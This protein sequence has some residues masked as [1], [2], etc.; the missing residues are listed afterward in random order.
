[1]KKHDDKWYKNFPYLTNKDISDVGRFN[2]P[3]LPILKDKVFRTKPGE[4]K[5]EDISNN[6]FQTSAD[7]NNLLNY[8]LAFIAKSISSVKKGDILCFNVIQNMPEPFH[9]MIYVGDP[10]FLVYHPDRSMRR[11][12]V[13]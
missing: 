2:Y 3:D 6:V 4:F 7:V 5:I 11:I 13:K 1:M 9:A 12:K 10:D 8:N